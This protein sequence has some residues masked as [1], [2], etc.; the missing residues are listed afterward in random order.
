MKDY[1]ELCDRI[2]SIIEKSNVDVP[3]CKNCK[4]YCDGS[5]NID[6][7]N[8]RNGGA[9]RFANTK[10]TT[11]DYSCDR[12]ESTYKLSEGTLDNLRDLI[13]DIN[14]VNEGIKGLDLLLSGKISEDEY[15][16]ILR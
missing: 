5:C 4:N 10:I 14:R 15:N 2:N 13:S 1:I 6:C 12:F 8:E 16:E 7:V 11:P 3:K 9:Y